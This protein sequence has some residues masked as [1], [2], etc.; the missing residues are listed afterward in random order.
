[1]P[2]GDTI[3]RTAAVL[4][5]ALQ[6]RRITR[7]ETTV[8]AVAAVAARAPVEGRTVSAVEPR[9]KHLLINLAS[10]QDPDP[11]TLHT[12]MMMTG[13]WHIYRP[14]EAWRKP[15]RRAVVALHTDAFVAPCFS[16]PVVE[17][18]TE[19]QVLQ[20]PA[21]T[22]LGPDASAVGF[23]PTEVLARL[24][25]HGD[26]PIGVVLLNQRVL[27]GVGNVF[28]SELLFRARV[29]PFARVKELSPQAQE[30]LVLD[31]QRLLAQNSGR[32]ARRTMPGLDE[33]ERLWVY[34]RS[35]EPCR[36]CGE[37]IRMRRQGLEGRSTYFCG[38]C[39]GVGL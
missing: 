19:R 21:L 2:E 34:G 30:A 27:A 16:A 22:A 29:S 8:P 5:R 31:S 28:K 20:H 1:M 38:R 4:R 3:F 37:A 13:A 18:L 36:V 11:L 15:A 7:F 39:Q 24:R 14:G 32:S 35:G 6:G 17:L 33:R 23:D 10:P 26:E 25:R 12:H 9:G